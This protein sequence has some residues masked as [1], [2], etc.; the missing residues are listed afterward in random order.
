MTSWYDSII[1]V[2]LRSIVLSRFKRVIFGCNQSPSTIEKRKG[3]K[4]RRRYQDLSGGNL[5]VSLPSLLVS[6]EYIALFD[7]IFTRRDVWWEISCVCFPRLVMDR[8]AILDGRLSS[9]RD[10]RLKGRREL[11][12]LNFFWSRSFSLPFKRTK[13]KQKLTRLLF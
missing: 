8:E 12:L 11:S 10:G 7:P 2:S 3:A 6:R 4:K 9:S 5:S 13:N 1:S